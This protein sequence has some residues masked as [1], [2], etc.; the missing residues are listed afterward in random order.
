MSTGHIRA[1]RRSIRND[2][3]R[4]LYDQALA[5]GWTARMGGSNHLRLLAPDGTTAMTISCTTSGNGRGVQNN[6]SI[7]KRWQR[8]QGETP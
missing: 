6:L 1:L 4:D 7:L 5:L 8:Q 3:Q 2:R